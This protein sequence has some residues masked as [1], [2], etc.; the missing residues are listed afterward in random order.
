MPFIPKIYIFSVVDDLYIIMGHWYSDNERGNPEGLKKKMLP[1][2]PLCP[3]QTLHGLA[4]DET[5]AS[6]KAMAQPLYRIFQVIFILVLS[7]FADLS[8]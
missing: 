2:W 1:L 6:A 4:W 5:L 7:D 3:P 8:K